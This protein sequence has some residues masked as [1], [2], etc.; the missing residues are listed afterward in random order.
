MTDYQK[1][2]DMHNMAIKK[3]QKILADYRAMKIDDNEFLMAKAEYDNASKDFD[4]AYSKAQ[5]G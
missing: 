2:I 4:K 3:Y 5:E 1:A